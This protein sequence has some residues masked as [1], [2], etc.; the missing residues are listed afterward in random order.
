[1]SKYNN[2]QCFKYT[3]RRVSVV[4]RHI[5]L[6]KG[7]FLSQQTKI[8]SLKTNRGVW[9]LLLILDIESEQNELDTQTACVSCGSSH[10]SWCV[11][12]QSPSF[13]IDS[14]LFDTLQTSPGSEITLSLSH[15]HTL[16]YRH[17]NL[18]DT[19]VKSNN[20]SAQWSAAANQSELRQPG[21]NMS[22]VLWRCVHAIISLLSSRWL[23]M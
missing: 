11:W 22:L 5:W 14:Q 1:M 16:K 2:H 17:P 4:F 7:Y 6:N 19:W 8:S 10:R 18:S 12:Q 23:C 15:T 20:P 13:Y 9:L 21:L 3:C